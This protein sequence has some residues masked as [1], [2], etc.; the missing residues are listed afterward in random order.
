MKFKKMFKKA[1]LFFT[2]MSLVIAAN[3]TFAFAEDSGTITVTFDAG[4][5]RFP[6]KGGP[7]IQKADLTVGE[8]YPERFLNPENIHRD[9][10]SCEGWFYYTENHEKIMIDKDS[11]VSEEATH[12]YA[13]WK[14]SSPDIFSSLLFNGSSTGHKDFVI[15]FYNDEGTDK[16][17]IDKLVN[18][19]RKYCEF[20]EE[21][22]RRSSSS[23]GHNYAELIDTFFELP[24][25]REAEE[26]SEEISVC[27]DPNDVYEKSL[28]ITENKPNGDP[29]RELVVIPHEQD[30]LLDTFSHWEINNVR[31]EAG[32][33]YI[34][35]LFNPNVDLECYAVY[36]DDKIDLSVAGKTGHKNYE[37]TYED[38]LGSN[39]E[40][41]EN[42]DFDIF[43]GREFFY[44]SNSDNS[45]EIWF[46]NE[47][48]ICQQHYTI[49]PIATDGYEPK[50][51]KFNGN[52]ISAGN[53]TYI[54]LEE[55]LNEGTLSLTFESEYSTINPKTGDTSQLM[56]YIVLLLL[57]SCTM[58][59]LTNNMKKNKNTK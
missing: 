27:I 11:L 12:I 49:R 31:I 9:G 58:F 26:L 14:A 38:G 8:K 40:T 41:L 50:S 43:A 13:D 33:E 53:R 45:L 42:I 15:R 46:G 34:F 47:E 21:L 2:V 39:T 51:W 59:V 37:V 7:H 5:G 48:E 23:L 24:Y 32:K 10:Y 35:N 20:P 30:D 19:I 25:N 17:Y 28:V 18:E 54:D 55:L 6:F 4:Y 29:V 52:A 22:I 1:V 44:R 16:N 36:K 3:V 57:A 56:L